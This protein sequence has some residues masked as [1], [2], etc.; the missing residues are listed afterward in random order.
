MVL[1]GE[2]SPGVLAALAR[3]EGHQD[4]PGRPDYAQQIS[5]KRIRAAVEIPPDFDAAVSSRRA[6]DRR[7]YMY[8]GELKSG[9]GADSVQKFFHDFREAIVRERL[10]RASCPQVW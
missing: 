7:I 3:P 6:V 4:R 9:F 1:G 10:R 2:D 5:E 8:Q